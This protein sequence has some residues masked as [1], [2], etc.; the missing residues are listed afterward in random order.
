MKLVVP[1]AITVQYLILAG[2]L[3][4]DEPALAGAAIFYGTAPPLDRVPHI[5]SPLIGFYAG[6]DERVNAGISA[7]AEALAAA[8]KSFERYVYPNA[9]H[10]FFNEDRPAYDANASRDAY[11][12]LLEFLRTHLSP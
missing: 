5:A 6:L 12:R 8:G 2:L 1:T 4:T 9:K 7:F 10:G 3:S 11:A